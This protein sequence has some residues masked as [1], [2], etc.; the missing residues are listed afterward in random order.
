MDQV[1]QSAGICELNGCSGFA[2]LQACLDACGN[3]EGEFCLVMQVRTSCLMP[4][5]AWEGL[6][7]IHKLLLVKSDVCY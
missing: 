1:T 7:Q 4:V 2:G 5:A 6:T 3:E